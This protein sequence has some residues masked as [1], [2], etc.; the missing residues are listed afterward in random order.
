MAHSGV[1]AMLIL[2][3]LCPTEPRPDIHRTFL[4]ATEHACLEYIRLTAAAESH[5]L[6][7][8]HPCPDHQLC[9]RLAF[10][11]FLYRQVVCPTATTPAGS[12]P[13]HTIR[14]RP[15]LGD[16]ERIHAA[17]RGRSALPRVRPRHWCPRISGLALGWSRPF[18][19][20]R[21]A[22]DHDGVRLVSPALR[23]RQRQRVR[24]RDSHQARLPGALT[25]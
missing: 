8:A 10:A 5:L 21:W 12:D 7:P 14:D 24:R 3:D 16:R 25:R 11:R 22:R 20:Q 23:G 9:R 1:C 2:P 15:G 19:T 4:S 13:T 18:A 17:L 6:P